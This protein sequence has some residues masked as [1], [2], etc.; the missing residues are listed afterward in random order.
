MKNVEKNMQTNIRNLN[1]NRIRTFLRFFCL[2]LFLAPGS[3]GKAGAQEV[4]VKKIVFDH[5][6]D[7]YE[8]HITHWGDQPVRIPLPVIVRG[9]TSGWHVFLS[10]R[11]DEGKIYNGFRIA[12]EGPHAGKVVE[13]N[14]AGEEVRPLDLSL[15][16]TALALLVNCVLLLAIVLG[17][18]RWYRKH[19]MEV[20]RGFVGL[21]EMLTM[22]IMNDVI[23]PCIGHNYAKYAPFLLTA[24]YFILVN[25]MMGIV[26]FFPAG[27]NTTGN[28]AITFILALSV[29]LVVNLF[30]SKEYWKEIFWPDVPV[31]LKVPLPL[32]PFIEIFGLFTKPFALMARL[33]ANIMAG[34]SVILGITSLV[35]I[36]VALGPAM[37]TGMSVVAVLFTVFMNCLELLVAFIQAYVF[38]ML[39]AVFIG[40]AQAKPKKEAT[41]KA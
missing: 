1:N 9:E 35:F 6:Q 28:I 12:A 19:P 5:I 16:K 29:F 34:H 23:K 13:N 3:A 37:N 22:S 7:A 4:D 32:M 2:L 17:V 25:N 31:W 39:S 41:G 33:F 10:S 18:V 11:L 20:P 38:T 36:S 30:G 15:T 21:V 26:P 14:A 24:F 8:W 27:A 40:L